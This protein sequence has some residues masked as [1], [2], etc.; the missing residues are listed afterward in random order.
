MKDEV[1]AIKP[2]QHS[3]HP[4]SFILHP[5]LKGALVVAELVERLPTAPLLTVDRITVAL[6]THLHGDDFA[7]TVGVQIKVVNEP[8]G[9][10]TRLADGV[11][12]GSAHDVLLCESFVV[13]ERGL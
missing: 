11:Y 5:S 10:H 12:A 7:R 8:L 9:V 6:K 3:F 1:K 13:R 2:L 4:S